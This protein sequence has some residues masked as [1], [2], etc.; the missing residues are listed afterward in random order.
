[1]KCNAFSTR[2]KIGNIRIKTSHSFHPSRT[3]ASLPFERVHE[4][5]LSRKVP[6]S[7]ETSFKR[8]RPYLLHQFK[9]EI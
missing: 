9:D 2:F 1:L 6:L 5:F 4:S 8:T 3:K 7:D